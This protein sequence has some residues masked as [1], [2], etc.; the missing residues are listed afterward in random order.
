MCQL[1]SWSEIQFSKLL[2]NLTIRLTSL[3]K[4]PLETIEATTKTITNSLV[5]L[6]ELRM[7][8]NYFTRH[9]DTEKEGW[10]REHIWRD[11]A[12][13]FV[14]SQLICFSSSYDSDLYILV[15]NIKRVST[16]TTLESIS[17]VVYF[18]HHYFILHFVH[19]FQEAIHG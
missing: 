13:L 18:D 9:C 11:C 17:I 7:N 10:N 16:P 5:I 3:Q 12:L 2:N 19:G 4:R 1:V 15:L 6:T 8:E 14:S